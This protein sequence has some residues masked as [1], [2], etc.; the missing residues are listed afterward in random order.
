MYINYDEYMRAIVGNTNINESNISEYNPQMFNTYIGREYRNIVAPTLKTIDLY[1]D[2]FIKVNPIVINKCKNFTEKITKDIILKI[3][4][5]IYL[6]VL[7]ENLDINKKQDKENNIQRSELKNKKENR[8]LYDFIQL[9][10]VNQLLTNKENRSFD[11][12]IFSN[13]NNANYI[14]DKDNNIF[15]RKYLKF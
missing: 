7:N 14:N 1:P 4:D 12:K 13:F 11:D 3:T 15:E 10:V 8:I 2:I 9:L 5:D 6:K